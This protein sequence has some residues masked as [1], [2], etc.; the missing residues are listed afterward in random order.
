MRRA[1]TC[2]PMPASTTTAN[3]TAI[4]SNPH[5]ES[6]GTAVEAAVGVGVGAGV[7]VGIGVGAGVGVGVGAAVTDTHCENSEVLLLG[8]VA[9]AVM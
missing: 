5:C 8:S 3:S 4:P 7:D 9:V 1:R 6:E 2:I